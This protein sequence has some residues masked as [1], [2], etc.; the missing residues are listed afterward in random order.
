MS[1][2]KGTEVR[3][4][5]CQRFGQ[6]AIQMGLIDVEQ[7]IAALSEQVRDDVEGRP[8]RVLGTIFFEQGVLTPGQIDQIL[9][10]LFRQQ[11]QNP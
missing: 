10:R 2:Q 11:E 6:I 7:L 8:H 5:Y 4:V 3:D 1:Q 9:N